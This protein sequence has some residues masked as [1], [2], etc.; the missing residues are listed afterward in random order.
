M[1]EERISTQVSLLQFTDALFPIG[2]YAHSSGLE[3]YAESGLVRDASGVKEVLISHL[4]GR[5]GPSDAVAVALSVGL[6]RQRDLER[7]LVLDWELD[8]QNHVA[9]FREASRQ[10]GHQTARVAA[11]LTNDPFVADYLEAVESVESTGTPGHHSVSFGITGGIIGWDPE[12]AAAAYLFSSAS[13]FVSA[14]TRLLPLGQMEAQRILW[15]VG[16]LIASLARETSGKNQGDI[17]SF[18]PGLEVAGMR[19]AKLR[20]RLFRS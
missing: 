5:T 7:C 14:A 4:Q 19:H 8:A 1:L 6:A 15:A 17:W 16:P 13:Q 18:S 20:Q 9:E 11:T 2:G 10:M 12:Q 3:Y